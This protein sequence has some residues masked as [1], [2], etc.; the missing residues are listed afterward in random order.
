MLRILLALTVA[1]TVAGCQTEAQQAP[2][3]STVV[4][5]GKT[6]RANWDRCLAQSF[7]VTRQQTPDKSAAA[8]MAFQ[9]C[10]TEEQLLAR[11]TVGRGVEPEIFLAAKARTKQT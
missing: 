4:T 3:E 5:I 8:E 9:S 2:A 1:G 10:A 7:A 6:L 11:F